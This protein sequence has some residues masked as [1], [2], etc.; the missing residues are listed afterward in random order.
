MLAT[1]LGLHLTA[2]SLMLWKDT[3]LQKDVCL[4]VTPTKMRGKNAGI[5]CTCGLITPTSTQ[6]DHTPSISPSVS[7]MRMS[8]IGELNSLVYV[9]ILYPNNSVNHAIPPDPRH[10]TRMPHLTYS[11]LGNGGSSDWFRQTRVQSL[12]VQG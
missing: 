3:S 1:Q 10:W 9:K 11:M 6:H 4:G 8:G 12:L 7:I 5:P 2:E